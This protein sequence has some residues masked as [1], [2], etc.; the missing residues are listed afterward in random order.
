M[1]MKSRQD[2]EALRPAL[3]RLAKHYGRYGYS[4]VAKLFCVEGWNVNH[5][6]AGY[7]ERFHKTL[8]REVPN[9]EWFANVE[10]AKTVIEKWLRQYNYTRPYQALGMR[11]P[12]PETI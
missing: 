10:Q 7:N 11:P 4:K 6:R 12:V 9:A 3:M 8:R 1:R 2:D 5:K